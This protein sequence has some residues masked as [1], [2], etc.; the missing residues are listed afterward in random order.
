M[1]ILGFDGAAD[2]NGCGHAAHGTACPQY[3]PELGFKFKNPGG[4]QVN[5]EP[6]DHGNN[7]SL[8]QGN[9]TGLDNDGERQRRSQQD[10]TGFDIVF[11]A[12]RCLKPV[13]NFNNIGDD[14]PD[15]EGQQRCFNVVIIHEFRSGRIKDQK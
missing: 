8:K 10:D 1:F 4:G 15:N 2:G 11:R 14:Q 3:R 7:G 13:G 5:G 6:G 12:E 9:G